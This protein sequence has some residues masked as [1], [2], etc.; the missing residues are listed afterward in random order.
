MFVIFFYFF[1]KELALKLPDAETLLLE[2]P[3]FVNTVLQEI[4]NEPAFSS[5]AKKVQAYAVRISELDVSVWRDFSRDLVWQLWTVI[6]TGSRN[7]LPIYDRETNL[8]KRAVWLGDKTIRQDLK[9]TFFF[10]C[11]EDTVIV[12]LFVYSFCIKLWDVL[13][14]FGLKWVNPDS[15]RPKD[16]RFSAKDDDDTLHFISGFILKKYVTKARNHLKNGDWRAIYKCIT[17]RFI[18]NADSQASP[19][20][21][22]VKQWTLQRS[23]GGLI[24]AGQEAFNFFSLLDKLLNTI[25]N[26]SHGDPSNICLAHDVVLNAVYGE[27]AILNAWSSLVGFSYFDEM[28]SLFLMEMMVKSYTNLYGFAC[29]SRERRAP[30]DPIPEDAPIRQHLLK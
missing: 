20:E 15:L 22:E 7:A 19:T 12:D 2:V 23:R 1:F 27:E 14:V 6:C 26:R 10:I 30:V 28:G 5:M 18:E 9:Q 11:P 8:R 16:S 24:V 17:E 29:A 13:V 21:K 25:E 4:R 3:D